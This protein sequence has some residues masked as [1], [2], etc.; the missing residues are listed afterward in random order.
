MEAIRTV[1]Q[2]YV[3]NSQGIII[4]DESIKMTKHGHQNAIVFIHGF[5][6]SPR[7]FLEIM[8]KMIIIKL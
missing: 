7:E 5:L 3:R 4:G 8:N 6:N 2:L 1:K